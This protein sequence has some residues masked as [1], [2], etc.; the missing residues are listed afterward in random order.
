[1]VNNEK[2]HP[3]DNV[4]LGDNA[5]GN[6]IITG[7][8]QGNV[9]IKQLIPSKPPTP[10]QLR[11][12]LDDFVGRES[13][14]TELLN[15]LQEGGRASI[16]GISGMGGIGKTE[17]ALIV[18]DR[19]R[20]HYP[21]AQ[22]FLEMQGT[23]ERPLTSAEALASCIRAFEG[24]EVR[25][26]DDAN[27]LSKIY[28]S[29]LSG[30][31]VMVVL[32]NA[33]DRNQVRLLTPPAGCALLVT[34]RNVIAG[35]GRITLDQLKPE[36]A[37]ELLRSI[38]LRIAPGVA[39]QICYLCGY[40]PLAIR[41]AGSLLDVTADLDP[42]YYARQL[43]D[44]Y[45]RLEAIGTEGVEISVEASFNLSYARLQPETARVFRYL[46]VF[47]ES[48]DAGAEESVCEDTGHKHLG[49]LLRRSLTLAD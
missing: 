29:V 20:G 19:L 26:P 34:S 46:G 17:L 28:L 31:R 36:E 1:M 39:D 43:T 2:H 13:E 15:I 27:E 37:R 6:V 24:P 4:N 14:I 32:D 42:A 30:K 33:A 18:A 48:F 7:G 16:S 35:M 11:K 9:A 25:L 23:D 41:A 49:E 12:S 38:C 45:T 10:H 22:L 47:P 3:S 21:D 40:L 8:V 44:E 5:Q